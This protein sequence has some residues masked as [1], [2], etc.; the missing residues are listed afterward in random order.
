MKM[1]ADK[2][3]KLQIEQKQMNLNNRVQWC[4]SGTIRNSQKD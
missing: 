4:I 2:A 3:E 1:I